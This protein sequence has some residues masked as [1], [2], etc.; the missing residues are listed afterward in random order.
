MKN[1]I[2]QFEKILKDELYKTLIDVND[3]AEKNFKGGVGYSLKKFREVFKN[4]KTD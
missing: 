2:E 3:E 4:E 1:K